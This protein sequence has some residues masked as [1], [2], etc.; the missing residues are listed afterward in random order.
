MNRTIDVN[1]CREDGVWIFHNGYTCSESVIYAIDKHF[2]LGMGTDAI[3][4][5]SGFP[6]G[7]GGGGCL[8]GAVAGSAMCLGY[9]FGR[10]Q[11]GDPC[12]DRCFVLTQEFHDRF[13]KEFGATCC[14]ALLR[15]M[16]RNAPERKERCARQVVFAIETVAEILQRELAKDG[17][18]GQGPSD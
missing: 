7:L 14:R 4:M 13:K 16:D 2:D 8:C 9:A 10:R 12:I 6:W 5:S 11:P 1:A 15:G 3:A 17:Q 18:G